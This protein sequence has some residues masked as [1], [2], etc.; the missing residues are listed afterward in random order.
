[1]ANRQPGGFT[2]IELLVVVAIAGI[3]ATIAIPSYL[4]YVQRAARADV[5]ATLLENAQFMERNFTEA[6]RYHQTSG[7]AAITLP[8]GQ[9]PKDGT[10]LYGITVA[11]ATT[12]FTLTAAPASGGRMD[13]D[14]CGSFTLNQLGQRGASGGSLSV[15]ECWNQ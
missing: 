7:G 9:S 12:T 6:N 13:G 3:L 4:N 15:A 1:M 10:A 14:A 2:L 11:A 5:K 8:Y